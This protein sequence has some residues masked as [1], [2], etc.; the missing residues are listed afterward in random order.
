MLS[1][2]TPVNVCVGAAGDAAEAADAPDIAEIAGI[3]DIA[4]RAAPA[5]RLA[6]MY[7]IVVLERSPPSDT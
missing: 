4:D 1:V 7:F 3:A 6:T 5:R 2:T